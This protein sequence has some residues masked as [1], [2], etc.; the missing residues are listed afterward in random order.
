MKMWSFQT[1]SIRNKLKWIVMGAVS[2]AILVSFVFSMVSIGK[3]TLDDERTQLVALTDVIA[4]NSASA[5]MFADSKSAAE[6]LGAL[7]I[8][9]GIIHAELI[10]NQGQVF[11]SYQNREYL[12]SVISKFIPGH[13]L[14]VV[15]RPA[16][17]AGEKV[18]ALHVTVDMVG[19]WKRLLLMGL[20]SLMGLGL[21]TLAGYAVMRRMSKL[22]LEPIERLA[23]T[24]REVSV[25][26]QY[27]LRA[28]KMFDDELGELTSEFNEMLD[29]IEARDARLQE[30]NEALSQTQEAIFVADEHAF[31]RYINPAFSKLLATR[32]RSWWE[33]LSP[34][35]SR[36]NPRA[37]R[38]RRI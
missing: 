12:S 10:D 7:S 38:R 6:T 27:S 4:L 36:H 11:A 32:R 29:L 25:S 2:V 16:V 13:T 22:I 9:G 5:L 30:S 1:Q 14:Y 20:F 8:R 26:R 31:F 15:E 24:A 19:M 3:Q 17:M 18:G 28:K 37:S 21:A 35:Q 34:C 23:K 33:S